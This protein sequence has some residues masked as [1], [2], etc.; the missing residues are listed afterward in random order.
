MTCVCISVYVHVCVHMD[1]VVYAGAHVCVH[2]CACTP[3][4]HSCACR[5]QAEVDIRYLPRLLSRASLL[6]IS[7]ALGL[8]VQSSV[9]AFFL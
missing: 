7:L 4:V 1:S 3:H 5:F 6:F 9:L 2:V 8:K